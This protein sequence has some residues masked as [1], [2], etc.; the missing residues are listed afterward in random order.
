M[1]C[2]HE[3]RGFSSFNFL[4]WIYS[5]DIENSQNNYDS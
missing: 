2:D 5:I 1:Q 4:A 3:F